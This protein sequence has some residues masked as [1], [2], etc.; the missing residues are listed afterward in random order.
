MAFQPVNLEAKWTKLEGNLSALVP[1]DHSSLWT[2]TIA[3]QTVVLRLENFISRRVVQDRLGVDAGLVGE[4]TLKVM[5]AVDPEVGV[6]Q[7]KRLTKPV[8]GLLKGMLICTALVSW[9][10]VMII[11]IK[12]G[13]LGYAGVQ[14]RGSRVCLRIPPGLHCIMMLGAE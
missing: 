2:H 12:V 6:M 10:P 3:G 14:H 9:C 8:M 7:S 13:S 1:I 11:I 4:G 5:L